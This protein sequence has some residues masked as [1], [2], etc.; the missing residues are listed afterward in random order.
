MNKREVITTGMELVGGVMIVVGI[1]FF[2][3][4]VG[5]IVAGLLLVVL[6]GLAA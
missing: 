1:S 5:V 4:P 6:G 2:S 3:V